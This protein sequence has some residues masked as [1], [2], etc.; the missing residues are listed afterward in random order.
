MRSTA[1]RWCSSCI[2]P[3]TR[4]NLVL[5]ES[6]ICNACETHRTKRTIDWAARESAFRDV[7]ENAKARSSGYDC[8]IPVSGGKDSTWQVVKCLEYGLNPLTVTW[9]TPGRTEVGER[10]LANLVRLGV[11]HID[12][13]INPAVERRFMYE[14]LRLY[15]STALPMHL[16]IFNIPARIATRFD[17]PLIVWG[18]NSAFE[19]GGTVEERT[20][21]K[22]DAVWLRRHG[23]THGT[24]AEDWLSKGFSRREL[25]PYFGPTPEQLEAAGVH[26]VFLGYY[27]EWD[28]ELTRAVASK[29]G[30]I[31]DARGARTGLYDYAD[32][33][34]DFISVHHWL[35]WYKFGF[36]RL[37]DNLS[38]EIRNARVTRD[39]AIEIVRRTG[40]DTPIEDI[41]KLCA[42]LEIAEEEFFD[43]CEQ[44]RNPAI[45]YKDG[46]VWKIRDFLI[47]DWD[48]SAGLRGTGRLREAT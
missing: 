39:E 28:P 45:W 2:L 44:F 1:L 17:I 12:Y 8:L 19:Y 41:R 15:G 3:D 42:F 20:G 16:A 48:W 9:R 22:L 35:K 27:F 14:A 13:Q 29:H 10:N 5:S 36:S 32:I 7:V 31:A 43:V 11:D 33:D 46:E 23:V 37:F 40:D 6:G 24:T 47:E 18:E 34:D 26:A 21:F 25:T 4:P 38:L 30:F